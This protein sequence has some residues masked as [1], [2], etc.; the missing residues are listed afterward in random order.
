MFEKPIVSIIIPVYNN[1]R[2]TFKCIKSIV[3]ENMNIP[4]E[5][6][7]ADEMSND[8]TKYINYFFVNVYINKNEKEHGFVMNCNMAANLA[9]GKYIAFLNN[10][11]QVKKGLLSN[12]V[13]LI[14]SSEKIGMVGSKLI[15][16]NGTLQEAGGI[17]WRD[18]S[19]YNYGKG[20]DSEMAEYNYVKEVDYI[21]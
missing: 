16:P 19:G 4:Y 11:V 10:D 17:I 13:K 15:Y 21:S 3:K 1:F 5:I 14:E 7:I 6:I 20:K 12:L 9:K 2:Y 8:L 18:G